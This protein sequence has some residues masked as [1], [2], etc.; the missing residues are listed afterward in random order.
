V[1]SNVDGFDLT[2]LRALVVG[3]VAAPVSAIAAACTAA[4]AL[5]T[6][7]LVAPEQ[8]AEVL[9]GAI[10][11]HDSLDI[12]VTGFDAFLAL[13]FSEITPGQLSSVILAN[14]TSQFTACQIAVAAMRKQHH[15]GRIV[16]LTSALGE[17][18]LANTTAYAAA[19]GAVHN[20]V[21]ALACEVAAEH[22]TINAISLGW[23]D[24]MDDRIDRADEQAARALRFP[25]I[26]RP[27][28]AAD[29]GPLVVWLC[30]GGAGY[31]TG[32]VFP[33]DGGLTQHL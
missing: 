2:G 1:S 17:R 29:I 11:A 5:V 22:I 21:R 3:N 28:C 14:F 30:G 8:S 7:R 31:V 24:W 23:M 33:L 19:H 32:Q 25:I 6:Q 26:K 18:G 4:G 16:L 13:P 15:G 12:L 20:L 9:P 27:G 10:A